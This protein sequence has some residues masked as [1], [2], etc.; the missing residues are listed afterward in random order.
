VGGKRIH[1]GDARIFAG[2]A[3]I[4]IN[5]GAATAEDVRRLAIRL[6]RKIK[7]E[8]GIKLEQEVVY[9]N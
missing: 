1:Q 2:H 4:L 9:I 6:R 3:N 5:S 8:F 7:R